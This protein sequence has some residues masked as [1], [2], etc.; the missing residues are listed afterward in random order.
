MT[1]GAKIAVLIAED[2][3]VLADVL[4]FNLFRAGFEVTVAHTGRE[5]ADHLRDERFDLLLT[6]YNMPELNG[7]ELIRLVREELGICDL[8]IVMCSAKGLEL[9]VERLRQEWRLDRVLYKP[10]SMREVLA[11]ARSLTACPAPT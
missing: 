6:D 4:R 3:I 1:T 2:N 10:F 11:V 9:D 7:E 5:A 8:P